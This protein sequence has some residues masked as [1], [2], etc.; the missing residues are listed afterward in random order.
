MELIS[1]I[2]DEKIEVKVQKLKNDMH[3]LSIDEEIIENTVQEMREKEGSKHLFTREETK[4]FI[5]K[6]LNKKLSDSTFTRVLKD[7]PF[8]AIK[9]S[10]RAGLRILKSSVYDYIKAETTSKGDLIKEINQLKKELAACKKLNE[11]KNK[12]SKNEQKNDMESSVCEGQITIDEV[13][14]EEYDYKNEINQLKSELRELEMHQSDELYMLIFDDK[15][16]KRYRK[17]DTKFYC[18]V[19]TVEEIEDKDKQQSTI[20]TIKE[21]LEKVREEKEVKLQKERERIE[22]LNNRTPEEVADDNV[23][24]L[25]E[26]LEKYD[27]HFTT[28]EAVISSMLAEMFHSNLITQEFMTDFSKKHLKE[29]FNVKNQYFDRLDRVILRYI[30]SNKTDYNYEQVFEDL[31]PQYRK[32][33]LKNNQNQKGDK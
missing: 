27:Y 21:Y 23:A 28:Y 17:E 31:I 3:K 29:H 9:A 5:E 13:I 2:K 33:F 12:C 4:Q 1:Q 7:F 25:R 26:R 19:E 6:E 8:Q 22:K 15:K 10:N 16:I 18:L 30:K 14:E 20:D 11:Q 32:I 24:L